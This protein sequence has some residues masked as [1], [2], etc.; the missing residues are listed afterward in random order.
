MFTAES[1]MT[2]TQTCYFCNTLSVITK[3]TIMVNDFPGISDA[4]W[5]VMHEVWRFE[6]ASTDSNSQP[7][8]Q[9][10]SGEVIA[11]LSETMDWSPGTVKTLLHRLVRKDVLEFQRK[12]NRYLY[13]AKF[14]EAQC[15]DWAGNQLL[16]SVFAGRPVPMLAWLVRSSRLSG[17][18]INSLSALLR[19]LQQ[20]QPPHTPRHRSSGTDCGAVT[21]ADHS[22]TSRIGHLKIYAPNDD[23]RNN[24]DQNSE[25]DRYA[26][27]HSESRRSLRRSA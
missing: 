3:D 5:H 12:G 10:T 6:S 13:R 20:Q 9:V 11:R 25:S 8:R 23:D 24:P 26:M 14:N 19:E 17:A 2:L 16:H 4:E 1:S 18:E 15:V 7:S 27:E 22:T 21:V